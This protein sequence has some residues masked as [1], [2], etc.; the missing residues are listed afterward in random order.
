MQLHERGIGEDQRQ[1]ADQPHRNRQLDRARYRMKAQ[2]GEDI[3]E[4]AAGQKGE[5]AG[6]RNRSPFAAL[7]PDFRVRVAPMEPIAGKEPVRRIP[8]LPAREVGRR[9]HDSAWPRRKWSFCRHRESAV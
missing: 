1:R 2:P 4:H 8:F 6:Y 3:G 5:W 9:P 7:P